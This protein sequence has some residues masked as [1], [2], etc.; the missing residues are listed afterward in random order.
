[1]K[2][3]AISKFQGT[4]VMLTVLIAVTLWMTNP[5]LAV[6]PGTRYADVVMVECANNTTLQVNV[7]VYFYSTNNTL[8]GWAYLVC[9]KNYN[10]MDA[11]SM[12]PHVLKPATWEAWIGF[13]DPD[14]NTTCSATDIEFPYTDTTFPVTITE[15]C[16]SQTATVTIGTP[17]IFP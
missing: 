16:G 1:M 10:T 3:H 8:I 5:S 9:G 12:V 17:R 4:I 15:T 11:D 14:T 7:T 2:H 13:Y 6:K